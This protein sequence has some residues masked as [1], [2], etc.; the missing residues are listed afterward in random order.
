MFQASE[1]DT[2][3]VHYTGRLADGTV[4][5]TSRDKK[6]LL[7]ILG[8]KEVIPGFEE[9]VL[10]MVKGENKTVRIPAEN[11]YG[12]HQAELVETLDRSLLPE[13]LEVQVGRQLEITMQDGNLL[14]VMVTDLDENTITLDGNHP[15]AG[16]ELTFDIE[17]L[18]VTR[19]AP[20]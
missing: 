4:F 12:S 3:K 20:R 5:D 6:P 15:L 8:K 14:R 16:K 17:L 9:A 1:K 2:V 10:G 13:S 11:A 7:F 19:A 18:E